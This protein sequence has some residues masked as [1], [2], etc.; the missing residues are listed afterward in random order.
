MRRKEKK[1]V[2]VTARTCE[3]LQALTLVVVLLV[4]TGGVVLTGPRRTLVDVDL[5]VVSL[6]ARHAEAL[7]RGHSVYTDGSV[8]TRLRQTLV[9]VLLAGLP[10]E[11]RRA[12]A[13]EA[14][15][16]Q[17]AAPVV[18]AGFVHAVGYVRLAVLSSEPRWTPA[19]VSVELI[20]AHGAGLGAGATRALVHLLG[21]V[22]PRQSVRTLAVVLRR[23]RDAGA[24]L[25]RRKGA[26]VVEFVAFFAHVPD[27]VPGADAGV[28]VHGVHAGSS[29]VA[30][31]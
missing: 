3:A 8:L 23:T 18:P 30:G 31:G 26:R 24:V 5:T 17:H 27:P 16:S 6:E 12:A 25:A 21:A 11:P 7:E 13:L 19:E 4:D 20:H 1:V 28:V 2:C 14:F 10:L 9:H 22:V 29:V 15:R